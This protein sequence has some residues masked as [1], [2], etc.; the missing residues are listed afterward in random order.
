MR[1]SEHSGPYPAKLPHALW[2][3]KAPFVN[4]LPLKGGLMPEGES[5]Q[6]YFTTIEHALGLSEADF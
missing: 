1:R 2:R 3:S 5:H 6:H 4:L